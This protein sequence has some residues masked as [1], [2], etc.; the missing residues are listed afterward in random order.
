M[1]HIERA[2]LNMSWPIQT[3]SRWWVPYWN[4]SAPR[5]GPIVL[6]EWK[7]CYLAMGQTSANLAPTSHAPIPLLTALGGRYFQVSVLQRVLVVYLTILTSFYISTDCLHYHWEQCGNQS[8][9][10]SSGAARKAHPILGQGFSLAQH[11]KHLYENSPWC[12]P[13]KRKKALVKTLI[14]PLMNTEQHP[15]LP[16][17]AFQAACSAA[18]QRKHLKTR[19]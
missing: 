19:F 3:G 17:G 13:R 6:R 4:Q 15:S 9:V 8:A 7:S 10:K 11:S 14:S 1:Q 12:S 5:M 16:Q 18:W 2:C